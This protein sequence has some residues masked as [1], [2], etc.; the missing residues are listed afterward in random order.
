MVAAG[1]A[2]TSWSRAYI[3]PEALHNATRRA[4]V[5]LDIGNLYVHQKHAQTL[6]DAGAFAGATKFVGC[7]FQFGDPDAANGAINAM[8]LNYAGDTVRDPATRN[9]QVQEPADVRIVLNSD[10]YWAD[11]DPLNGWGLDYTQDTDGDGAGDPCNERALD[12][13][14]TDDDAPLLFGFLPMVI[15]PKR[16]ARVEIRQIKEQSGMLPWACPT[17]SPRPSSRSSSTRTST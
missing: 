9:L 11:N 8:A 13:K 4:V 1:S 16:K 17:S 12:V 7:S 3:R 5:V 6:V 2:G 15:D 14:G 10:R